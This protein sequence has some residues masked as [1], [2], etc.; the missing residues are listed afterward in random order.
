MKIEINVKL[1]LNQFQNWMHFDGD[2]CG[3]ACAMRTQN[4]HT[5]TSLGLAH[6]NKHYSM[7]MKLEFNAF[8]TT[9]K[10]LN[11]ISGMVGMRQNSA[12]FPFCTIFQT[13][14]FHIR[15]PIFL[16]FPSRQPITSRITFISPLSVMCKIVCYYGKRQ[17]ATQ[18]TYFP[19]DSLYWTVT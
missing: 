9:F 14:I 1:G 10:R 6:L 7:E 3:F 8:L 19:I 4:L 13:T 12:L 5:K 11:W 15:I 18:N 2:F 16:S 17:P